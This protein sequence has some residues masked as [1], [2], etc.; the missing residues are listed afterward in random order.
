M[1]EEAPDRRVCDARITL[2]TSVAAYPCP[3][4]GGTIYVL[5][6]ALNPLSPAYR[7]PHVCDE[8]AI[9]DRLERVEPHH[10]GARAS[11]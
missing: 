9:A 6:A 11:A 8:A 5:K 2:V 10:V 3:R 1:D 4:C 7:K